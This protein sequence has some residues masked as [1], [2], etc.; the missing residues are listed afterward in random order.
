MPLF[1]KGDKVKRKDGLPFS[2]GDEIVTVD[3]V[4]LHPFNAGDMVYFQEKGLGWIYTDQIEKHKTSF[5]EALEA[6]EK[7]LNIYQH[8]LNEF[9][10]KV[11]QLKRTLES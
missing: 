7:E 2:N 6:F 1:K 5:E 3:Y 11:E 9:T 4:Q 10:K 8:V